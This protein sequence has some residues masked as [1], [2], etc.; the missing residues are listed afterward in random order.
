MESTLDSLREQ[1]HRRFAPLARYR[2][3]VWKVILESYLQEK[4][5]YNKIVLDLGCG[6]GEFINNVQASKKYAIDLNSDGKIHLSREICFIN[7]D[8]ATD[9]PLE[10]ESVDVIF[11]SNFFE[12]LISK[13]ELL[14]TLKQA[15][16][17]LKTNGKIICMGPNIK[18]I[19]KAYWDFF[20]HHLPLSHLS[21]IEGLE[22][23][24]FRVTSTHPKFLPYTMAHGLRPP[25]FLV[26]LYLQLPMLWMLF[27]KQ[28]LITATKS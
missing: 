10:N 1:Y 26:K 7:S 12:H 22:L 17:C 6:W 14:L 9:W 4:I 15:F 19:G 3:E 2:S 24:G 27:G 28:F 20:D 13:H 21:V 8:S 5:G 25:I 16:R 18:Y 11:T 23:A